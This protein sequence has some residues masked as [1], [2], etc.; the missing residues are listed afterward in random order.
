MDLASLRLTSYSRLWIKRDNLLRR[1]KREVL[2]TLFKTREPEN[3][4][5]FSGS[6]PFIQNK[7]GEGGGGCWYKFKLVEQT[8]QPGLLIWSLSVRPDYFL[9]SHLDTPSL[10]KTLMCP[11]R[12]FRHVCAP[13]VSIRFELPNEFV[14]IIALK[15]LLWVNFKD[16]TA[17]II[18]HL[19]LFQFYH[20][21][22]RQWLIWIFN[23]IVGLW[24]SAFTILLQRVLTEGRIP[25]DTIAD[26]SNR[27]DLREELSMWF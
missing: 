17:K 20:H 2:Y 4:I 3:H 27:G 21:W 25:D 16:L 9:R 10:V 18:N 26:M 1:L 14:L 13:F 5:Q 22:S 7:E 11:P 19:Q 12:I 6:W 8:P 23:V 24:G 15:I